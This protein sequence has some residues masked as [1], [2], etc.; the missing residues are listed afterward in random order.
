[1]TQRPLRILT[2]APAPASRTPADVE[3][4]AVPVAGGGWLVPADVTPEQ[5]R[6]LHRAVY[7]ASQRP[8]PHESTCRTRADERASLRATLTALAGR[9]GDTALHAA[10]RL[11]AAHG[12]RAR[13]VLATT[14][15]AWGPNADRIDELLERAGLPAWRLL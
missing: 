12:D 6:E 2:V 10:A 14:R 9:S 5:R 15:G 11:Y 8:A 1:M 4:D 7:Q 13:A 3:L